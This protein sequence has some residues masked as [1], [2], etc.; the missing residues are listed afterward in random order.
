[1]E[2]QKQLDFRLKTMGVDP[3]RINEKRLKNPDKFEE[4]DEELNC[5]RTSF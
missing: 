5:P 4:I 1:M 3:R 2:R